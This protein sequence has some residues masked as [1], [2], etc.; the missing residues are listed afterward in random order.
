MRDLTKVTVFVQSWN[1]QSMSPAIPP[2]F[3]LMGIWGVMWTVV[4]LNNVQGVRHTSYDLSVAKPFLPLFSCD[5]N[6]FMISIEVRK[7]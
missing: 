5:H 3:A 2:T 6:E 4:M 1:A 7:A